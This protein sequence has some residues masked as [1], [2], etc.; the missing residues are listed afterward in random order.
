MEITVQKLSRIVVG[1]NQVDQWCDAL[2]RILPQYD[3]NTVPRVAAFI[4]QCGHESAGFRVLQENLNY[5]ADALVRVWPGRFPNLAF[6]QGYAR[7]PEKI[8]N[9]A[10]SNRMGNG[11]E[12]S[13]D[14]WRYRGRGLIQLTGKNNYNALATS[15]G[16]DLNSM[17]AWLETIDGAVYSAC[18]YWSTNR[19]NRWVDA[20][21]F[22]GL[23]DSINIGRKTAAIGDS[24]GYVDR[25]N[26]YQLALQVLGS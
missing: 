17:P 9:R 22:D 2:N 18:W 6:A 11:D 4:A 12:G 13:G 26:R 21:D 16:R 19:L 1:N 8:A 7:Q 25:W 15:L 24:H 14:G 23:S 10:Y 5:R 3:I 20:N